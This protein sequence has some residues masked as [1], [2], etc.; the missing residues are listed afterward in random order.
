MKWDDMGPQMRALAA[1]PL[2]ERAETLRK[3]IETASGTTRGALEDRLAAV[4]AALE[5]LGERA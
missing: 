5:K 2:H 1:E 4:V 3:T